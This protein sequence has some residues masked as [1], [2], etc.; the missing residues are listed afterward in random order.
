MFITD[1]T[2]DIILFYKQTGPSTVR[3]VTTEKDIPDGE[4]EKYKKVTFKTRPLT[5]KQHNDIQSS[6]TVDRGA[7]MGSELDWVK[8]KEAKLIAILSGWDAT[9]SDGKNVPLSRDNI[10]KLQPIVAETILNEF[11][12]K[13]MVGEEDRK[14][15]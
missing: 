10:F 14:N 6:A 12:K 5:W 9:D 8:Y 2:I 3:V 7:G 4:E 15:S 1:D 11:D 13:T